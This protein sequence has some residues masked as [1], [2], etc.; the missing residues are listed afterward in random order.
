M[1]FISKKAAIWASAVLLLLLAALIW[2]QQPQPTTQHLPALPLWKVA[3][4]SQINIFNHDKHI[5]QAYRQG[6]LW[7]NKAA[8]QT[9]NQQSIEQLLTDLQDMQIKRVVSNTPQYFARFSVSKQDIHVQ[10]LD[11]QGLDLLHVWVGKASS[12]LVSTYL[13]LWEENRVMT[14][15]KILTWQVRRSPESWLENTDEE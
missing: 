1:N 14:V 6:Q 9:F 2:Q 15:D 7:Q 10:L 5:L 8:E 13:R 3:D 12:E 11:A 4:V